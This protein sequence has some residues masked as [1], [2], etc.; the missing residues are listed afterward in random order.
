[1]KVLS[2]ECYGAGTGIFEL[3]IMQRLTSSNPEH[4]GYQHISTLQDS[5]RHEGPN[6]THACLIMKVMGES[7]S[8]FANWFENRLIPAP[9]VQLYT[10]QLMQALDYAHSC[11]VIHTGKFTREMM[12][13]KYANPHWVDIQPSNIMM[14]VPDESLIEK[15]LETSEP[16]TSPDSQD[17]SSPIVPT[18]SLREFYFP[19]DENY[20]LKEVPVALVDWGVAS[21]VDKPLTEHIQPML[22]RSPEVILE[23]PWSTAVDIW[24]L[25]ALVP[26]LLYAQR[27]FSGVSPEGKYTT[28]QHLEEIA[29]LLGPFPKSLL[30]S[31]N[32]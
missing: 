27:T 18:Q 31:G 14:Q 8:S 17:S 11:G 24:N 6:G 9:L 19:D 13:L 28:E 23:A 20:N 10:Y 32:Q 30:D 12:E 15:W 25:G 7:L 22:L 21:W 16:A 3:E 1:M 5:F 4:D 29:T 2:A 26:E